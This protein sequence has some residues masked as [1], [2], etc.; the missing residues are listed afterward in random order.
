VTDLIAKKSKEQSH[1]ESILK[2]VSSDLKEKQSD[3]ETVRRRHKDYVR[4]ALVIAHADA[5]SRQSLFNTN[6]KR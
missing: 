3:L 2:Y 1:T 6:K 5:R 4:H